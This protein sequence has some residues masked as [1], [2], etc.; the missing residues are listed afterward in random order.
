M[1]AWFLN[2]DAAGRQ[3]AE[4]PPGRPG[5]LDLCRY[6]LA[7]SG[8]TPSTDSIVSYVSFRTETV[9]TL[10]MSHV[11]MVFCSFRVPAGFHSGQRR[12]A[13]PVPETAA[14]SR[15][16]ARLHH[17][18]QRPAT[19]AWKAFLL[20]HPPWAGCEHQRDAAADL[21]GGPD[22]MLRVSAE[23][24]LPAHQQGGPR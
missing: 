22:P 6:K 7:S 20:D 14:R 21:F 23:R 8:S 10:H 24:M 4:R 9:M 2:G 18:A 17:F 3:R 13:G 5:C 12:C 1:R 15:S 19:G 16:N 11:F